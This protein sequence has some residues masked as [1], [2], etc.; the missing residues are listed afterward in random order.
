MINVNNSVKKTAIL[1][2]VLFIIPFQ[3][4]YSQ[5]S[6]FYVY[7]IQNGKRINIKKG[8]VELKKSPFNMYVEYIEPIDL[9]V[10]S[11]NSSKT[12]LKSQKGKLMFYLPAFS[13]MSEPESFF[14][15][16]NTLITND[17]VSI[18]KKGKT[19]GKE[20]LKTDKNHF[21]VSKHIDKVFN[22]DKN[23]ETLLKDIKK[24]AYIVFI[25]AEKD[26]DGDFQEIQRENVK[27]KWVDKYYEETKA[28]ARKK[29]IQGKQKISQAKKQLKRKN[30]LAK[31]EEKRLKKIEE[32]KQKKAKKEMKKHKQK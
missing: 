12:Y 23:T 17:K 25:Y 28:F 2:I 30:K 15:K 9:L 3:K 11:S 7:F 22:S 31:K 4:N 24:K 14:A 18:W 10:S 26:K 6:S 19:D 5:T 20:I 27:I 32:H 1:L 13:Q 8:K 16:K 21:V 29:R